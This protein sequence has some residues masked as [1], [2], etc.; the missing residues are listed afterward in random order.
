MSHTTKTATECGWVEGCRVMTDEYS[1]GVIKTRPSVA[2]YL[3]AQHTKNMLE[4]MPIFEHDTK[5][6]I[7]EL[8]QEIRHLSFKLMILSWVIAAGVHIFMFIVVLSSK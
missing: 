8:R 3:K 2:D 6:T 5:V 4:R 7:E 1:R